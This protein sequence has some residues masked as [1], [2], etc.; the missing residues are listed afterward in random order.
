[1]TVVM[2]IETQEIEQLSRRV[3]ELAAHDSGDL[4]K[5]QLIDV[6]HAIAQLERVVGALSSR[7]AGELA[8]RSTPDHFGGGLARQQGFGTPGG[9]ISKIR[10]GS[11]GGA[12]RSINAGDAFTPRPPTPSDSNSNRADAQAKQSPGPKYPVV[13][14]KSL[15][16]ELSVDAA[17]LIVEGLNKVR[18]S[19]SQEQLDT[20][21]QRFVDKAVTMTSHQVQKMVTRAVARVNRADHEERERRNHEERYVWWKQ[22]SDG[23][24][25]IHGVMDAV[26]AAPIINVLE[27]ITTRDVR[28]KGRDESKDADT[29]TVGQMRADALN[30]LARHALGCEDTRKSGVRTSIIVRMGLSD[31]MRGQGIGSI[32]GIE[33]PVSVAEMRRL[34]GEAGIIPEVLGGDG[35]VLDFGR[36]KRFFTAA[37]RKVL[38]ARDGGCAKC[39]APPEHCEAH[40][41]RWWEHGGDTYLPNGDM[42]CTRCHHDVH[43]QGWEINASSTGV[44]FIPPP[45]IDPDQEEQPGGAS[46]FDI[47]LPAGEADLPPVTPEDEAFVRALSDEDWARQQASWAKY[48]DPALEVVY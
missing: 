16:G 11:V 12:K 25:V 26:T 31:L 36:S 47:D 35:E 46:M 27:Q 45:H 22:Q 5:D 6:V 8:Q 24:V 42:L 48:G 13:A 19:L 9:M 44:S 3:G 1:M 2:V 14:E 7:Y 43:R 33:Q 29:R 17:G 21:E 10:G 37:Q 15:A 40:H 41:I 39:H 4:S 20:L 28:L 18:E 34:A 23:N 30:F 32:D 38:L